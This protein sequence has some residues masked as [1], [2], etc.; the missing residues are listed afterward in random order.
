MRWEDEGII[1]SS[2]IH[3]ECNAILEVL[4]LSHGRHAGLVRNAYSKKSVN[5]LQ[6]GMQLNLIWTARLNEH[7][8]AFSLDKIKSRTSA[9]IRSKRTLLGF[10]SLI[11]LQNLSLPEREPFKR[12]YE[13]TKDLVDLMSDNSNWLAGYVRWELMILSELGFGL[14]LSKCAVTGKNS[15]LVYVSP[16]TGRAVSSLAGKEWEK[17]LL[18]LPKFLTTSS[19]VNE[20]NPLMISRGMI[21]T[22]F[23]LEK[24]ILRDLG[25]MSLPDARD[26]FFMSLND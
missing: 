5:E 10:N 3:G 8:G 1:L 14:D 13:S 21:L 20:A 17:R 18:H 22:G 7:L 23:F 6:P 15:D 19:D 26:R 12:I 24:W 9:L 16:R 11:S 2:R 25:K 4:T